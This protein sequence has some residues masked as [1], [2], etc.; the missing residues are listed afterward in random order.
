MAIYSR[1]LDKPVACQVYKTSTQSLSASAGGKTTLTWGATDIDTHDMWTSSSNTRITIPQD[2]IYSITCALEIDPL[3]GYPHKRMRV[4]QNGSE[5]SHL[6]AS[7]FEGTTTG[8]VL[9]VFMS[10]NFL[11]EAAEDDYLE[12][13]VEQAHPGGATGT[14]NAAVEGT[15]MSVV[16]LGAS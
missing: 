5:L 6:D 4:K 13:V 11:L 14:S 8:G 10:S 2:G 12:L 15:W 9:I 1:W 7:N 16:R 3:T